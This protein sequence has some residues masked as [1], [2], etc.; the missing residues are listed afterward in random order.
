MPD[1]RDLRFIPVAK[2]LT[3]ISPEAEEIRSA[4]L[5]A[6][7]AAEETVKHAGVAVRKAVECGRKLMEARDQHTIRQGKRRTG[8]FQA[9][10]AAELPEIPQAT[11]YRWIKLAESPEELWKDAISLRQAYIDVGIL[12]APAPNPQGEGETK[13]ADNYVVHLARAERALQLQ[14]S[15]VA[16]MSTQEKKLLK[17]RLEPL[18]HIYQAL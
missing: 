14:I 17:D 4:W 1:W 6:N 10:L 9:W 18:V 11:A 13:P 5:A 15:H 12:P 16:K 7:A 2:P 8:D 3:I